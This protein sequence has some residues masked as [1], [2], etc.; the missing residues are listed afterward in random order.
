[1]EGGR[2]QVFSQVRKKPTYFEFEAGNKI[3]SKTKDRQTDKQTNKY[4]NAF[5][6]KQTLTRQTKPLFEVGSLVFKLR[7]SF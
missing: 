6:A 7:Q 3:L 5:E 4:A 2:L 1:M